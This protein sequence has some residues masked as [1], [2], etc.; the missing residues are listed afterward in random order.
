MSM[1]VLFWR[2]AIEVGEQQ[3]AQDISA[4]LSHD[5]CLPIAMKPKSDQHRKM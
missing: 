5:I 4:P 2:D 3:S 1:I